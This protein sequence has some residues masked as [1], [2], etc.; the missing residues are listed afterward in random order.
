MNNALVNLHDTHMHPS[1]TT[2]LIASNLNLALSMQ[3]RCTDFLTTRNK[4]VPQY[5]LAPLLSIMT[6]L[7]YNQDEK[8]EKF[9][10]SPGA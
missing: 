1:T 6:E 9:G 7:Y 4:T 5:S 10:I 2:R 3:T 8:L